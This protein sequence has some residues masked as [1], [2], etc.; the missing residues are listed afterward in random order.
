MGL[1]CR[2]QGSFA[3]GRALL[4]NPQVS[5]LAKQQALGEQG[6]GGGAEGSF[7]HKSRRC[8]YI[9]M[10]IKLRT[11]D[12]SAT[13]CKLTGLSAGCMRAG[14]FMSAIT[15]HMG[16]QTDLATSPDDFN[17]PTSGAGQE[18][19]VSVMTEK[20]SSDPAGIGRPFKRS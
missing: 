6:R 19:R 4:R 8:T 18:A 5:Q 3:I 1:F 16:W 13:K 2:L 7:G 14:S 15:A 9:S 11:P 20:S 10:K 17:T 12:E